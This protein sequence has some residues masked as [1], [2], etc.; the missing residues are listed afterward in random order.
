MRGEVAD[1]GREGSDGGVFDGA[2][3]E[4]GVESVGTESAELEGGVVVLGRVY[5]LYGG[6]VQGVREHSVFEVDSRGHRHGVGVE[7]AGDAPDDDEAVHV[8]DGCGECDGGES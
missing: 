2:E 6:E 7:G 1:G 8:G 4:E 5:H 3:V